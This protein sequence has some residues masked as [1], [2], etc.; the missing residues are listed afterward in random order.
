MSDFRTVTN[1]QNEPGVSCHN[2]KQEV[3]EDYNEIVPVGPQSQLEA[4]LT[5]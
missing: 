3:T 2:Q 1:V 4:T 5:G